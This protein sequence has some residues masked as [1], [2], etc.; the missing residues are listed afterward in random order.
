[1]QWPLCLASIRFA[2]AWYASSGF[3]QCGLQT[4]STW[5]CTHGTA[6]HQSAFCDCQGERFLALSL[7]NKFSAAYEHVKQWLLS[8]SRA[9]GRH[10]EYTRLS[11]TFMSSSGS[12]IAATGGAPAS[13]HRSLC[14]SQLALHKLDETSMQLWHE[15]PVSMYC[16]C[17]KEWSEG[18]PISASEMLE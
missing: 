8:E 18:G 2:H 14:I 17:N 15:Q 3:M 12:L 1:M 5:A 10:I 7:F 13:H 6:C 11:S 9:S 4:S 16:S